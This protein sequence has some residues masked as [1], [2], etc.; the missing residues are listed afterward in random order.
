MNQLTTVISKFDT[1]IRTISLNAHD[2]MF[3]GTM[4]IYVRNAEKLNTLMDKLKKVQGIF[5]VERLV[6]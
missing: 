2:G 6:S 5:T 3:V 4:M 1:N